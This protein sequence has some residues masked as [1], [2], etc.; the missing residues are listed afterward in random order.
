MT[1]TASGELTRPGYR[2][3][4]RE[5]RESR[6]EGVDQRAGKREQIRESR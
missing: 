5:R 2:E 3:E 4:M 6:R 1:S